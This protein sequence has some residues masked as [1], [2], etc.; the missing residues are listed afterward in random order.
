M[1]GMAAAFVLS[2][3]DLERQTRLRRAK[4]FAASLLVI[5]AAVFLAVRSAA[6]DGTTWAGYVSAAAQAGMVGGLADWFAVTALFRRPLGLP[7]PHTALIPNRKDA[8]GDSLSSFVGDNFLSAEVVRRRLQQVDVLARLGG[9]LA[10]PESAK[11]VTAEAATA[12]R[13]ALEVLNDEDVRAVVEQVVTRRLRDAQVAPVLGRLLGQVVA[14]GSHRALVD[15]TA[16]RTAAWLHANRDVV[17]KVIES[18]APAWSPAFVDRALSRRV[19]AELLR[20]AE[21][22]VVNPKHAIR[23]AIDRWL[24]KLAQDL[25]E[26][27]ETAVRLRELTDRLLNHEGTREALGTLVGA[28]RR[29]V[30][31]L[32]DEPDGELRAR[33]AASVQRWGKRLVS[34]AALRAKL[35]RWIGDA[36]EHVVTTYREEITKTITDTV[37]RWD[38]SEAA[39]RIELVAG[40]DLQ[41]IRVNGTVVG[42]LAGVAIH[43]ISLLLG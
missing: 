28:T 2:P 14:D 32:I 10:K 40:R 33:T 37:D 8:L 39:R 15:V 30:V 34:D 43:A 5:A 31:D 18:E 23:L 17:I 7:I 6:D 22:V 3:A 29:A 24:A 36:V 35:D 13:A 1:P 26:D 41:F 9:W 27:P 25:R 16:Q 38:G 20:V 12:L 42:A 4:G 19:Y 21:Q 11:R